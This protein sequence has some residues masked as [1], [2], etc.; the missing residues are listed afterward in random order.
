M[1]QPP[2]TYAQIA[3][4]LRRPE[5]SLQFRYLLDCRRTGLLML[6]AELEEHHDNRVAVISAGLVNIDDRLAVTVQLLN[7]MA[8][9]W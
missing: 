3:G 5:P 2:E 8:G 9:I 7:G 6:R 1:I 4:R